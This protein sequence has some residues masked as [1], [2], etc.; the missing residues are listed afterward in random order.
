MEVSGQHHAPV[1]LGP[2]KNPGT[3]WVGGWAVLTAG[4]DALKRKTA[5]PPGIWTADC[6]AQS[7]DTTLTELSWLCSIYKSNITFW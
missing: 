7:L 6:E 1:I 5:A 2:E 4:V 3:H